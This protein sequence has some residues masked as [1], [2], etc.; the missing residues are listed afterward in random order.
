MSTGKRGHGWT[1]NLSRAVWQNVRKRYF[2]KNP[3]D[4]TGNYKCALCNKYIIDEPV[5]LDHII[6]VAQL[7]DDKEKWKDH[8]NLQPAHERCN[9]L[10][11]GRKKTGTYKI[12]DTPSGKLLKEV[13]L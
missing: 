10:K 7:G 1:Q 11:G 9:R 6:P 2:E 12:G 13:E 8:N 4:K 3:P 5:T